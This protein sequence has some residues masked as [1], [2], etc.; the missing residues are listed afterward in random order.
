MK[1][2]LFI[3]FLF[4]LTVFAAKEE[5]DYYKILGVRRDAN[6]DQIKK[7][8]KKLAIRYHPDKNQDNAEEAKN[9]FQ[10][11]AN[12]Y[13]TLSDPDKR[14]LYDQV[15]AEGMRQGPGGGGGG[16]QRGPGGGGPGVDD[17]FKQFFGG[18]AGPGGPGGPKMTF[19]FG[20][21]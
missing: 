19:S 14:R 15:G 18:G 6:E 4:L 20:N 9:K 3:L 10:K 12:A 8:F 5:D 11:I 7:A 2:Q 17:I 16:F 13:E 1:L 21:N